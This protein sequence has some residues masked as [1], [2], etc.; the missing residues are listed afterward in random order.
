M[1][2]EVEQRLR[3]Y[4]LWEQTTLRPYVSHQKALEL[5][6][7]AQILLLIEIDSE[8]TKGIVPGKMF[9]YMAAARPVLAVGPEG[10]EAAARLEDAK[11]GRGFTYNDQIT[12]TTLLRDWYGR[13]RKGTL[14][15]STEGV[16]GYSR[17]ALT[18]QLAKV[19]WES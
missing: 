19:L 5:Q 15:Q 4:G 16:M 3:D 1:S 17:A 9:E 10:W 11:C 2:P 7:S 14:T 8:A 12:I 6:R 18:E 13:Y